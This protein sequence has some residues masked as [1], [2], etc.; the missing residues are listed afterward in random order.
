MDLR[1]ADWYTKE[2]CGF[3]IAKGAEE[4]ENLQFAEFEKNFQIC[5]AIH[6]HADRLVVSW[7]SV[8]IVPVFH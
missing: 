1:F 6:T 2:I 3:G 5:L 4:P 7:T 8:H